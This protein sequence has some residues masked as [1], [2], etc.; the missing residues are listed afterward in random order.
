MVYKIF[1]YQKTASGAA[2][3][4]ILLFL[5]R[6]MSY[7]SLYEFPRKYLYV[8]TFHLFYMLFQPLSELLSDFLIVLILNE[9]VPLRAVYPIII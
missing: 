1:L 5:I 6:D 7:L 3:L 9:I 2:L 8:D 4:L